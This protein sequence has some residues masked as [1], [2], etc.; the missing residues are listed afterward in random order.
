M[1]KK[2][3][4]IYDAAVAKILTRRISTAPTMYMELAADVPR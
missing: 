1:H 2:Q 4:L 3:K